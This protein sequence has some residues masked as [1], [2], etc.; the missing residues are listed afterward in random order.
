MEE[1][2]QDEDMKKVLEDALRNEN[3]ESIVKKTNKE[4]CDVKTNILNELNITNDK[5]KDIYN[6]LEDY[7]YIDDINEFKEG[8][9]IRWINLKNISDIDNL[10]LTSG[11]VISEIKLKDDDIRIVCKLPFGKRAKYMEIL[12]GSCLIF[13]KLSDQEKIILSVLDYLN[14]D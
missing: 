8:S 1:I 3:N 10:K 7:R 2:L 11:A 9:F 14:K 12:G 13:Q 6:R 4:I 5:R